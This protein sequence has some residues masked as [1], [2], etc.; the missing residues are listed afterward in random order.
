LKWGLKKKL[1]QEKKNDL[2]VKGN[3]GEGDDVLKHY[4]LFIK[5]GTNPLIMYPQGSREKV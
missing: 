5:N 1:E 3:E 2:A 4:A